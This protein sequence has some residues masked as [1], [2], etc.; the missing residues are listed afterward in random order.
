MSLKK[1]LLNEKQQNRP[2][3]EDLSSKNILKADKIAPGLL[4]A[5]LKLE[6]NIV[7]D[8]ISHHLETK[9]KN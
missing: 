3:R 6:K 8:T 1:D 4:E 9:Q 5:K 7:C 2:S